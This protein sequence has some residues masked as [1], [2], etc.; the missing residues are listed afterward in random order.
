MAGNLFGV[1]DVQTVKVWSRKTE[2]EVLKK[3]IL[4][5]LIGNNS[6]SVVQV[7]DELSKGPGDRIRIPLRMQLAGYG[8]QGHNPLENN[9]QQQT[10]Y[11]DDL[12]IDQLREG[13]RWYGGISDQRVVF[14]QREE[15]KVALSDWGAH[16]LD[17]WFLNQVCAGYSVTDQRLTGL[18]AV[19]TV[20]KSTDAQHY[21]NAETP[22]VGG[23]SDD[24]NLDSNDLFTLSL[25]DEALRR[26]KTSSPAIRPIKINGGDY[27]VLVLHPNQV[28]DLQVATSGTPF[29]WT[30][31]QQS[32]MEGGEITG[33]PIFTGA[34]GMYKGV[35]LMESNRIPNG[36]SGATGLAVANTRR[37]CF[38]G[39]QSA[40]MGIGREQP[41]AERW[42]WKEKSF[43]YEDQYGIRV[44]FVGGL[45]KSVF[46]SASLGSI[47]IS[48]YT[49]VA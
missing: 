43:D 20:N 5:K 27:Y 37:A 32:A 44:K 14:D 22:T 29:S 10:Y 47:V 25:I 26:A 19:A 30:A 16:T 12:V 40:W 9:E 42:S 46:N 21:I 13:V 2:R 36:V 33:N 3:C 39:A 24:E 35:I 48:S 1:N 34:L 38:L 18:Q 8:V 11:Y 15:A 49:S 45:K 28:Y 7:K 4:S 41:G 17:T 31:L 23:A 6:D